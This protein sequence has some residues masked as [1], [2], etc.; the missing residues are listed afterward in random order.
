MIELLEHR[1]NEETDELT[2]TADKYVTTEKQ[3]ISKDMIYGTE[4]KLIR[5]D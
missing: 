4:L 3:L 2:I 5:H 1:Y